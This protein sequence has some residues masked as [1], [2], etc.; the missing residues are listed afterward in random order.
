MCK[1]EMNDTFT[2]ADLVTHKGHI[3]KDR[4][5]ANGART[6]DALSIIQLYR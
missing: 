4:E 5:Q 2:S 6:Q 3:W 1:S